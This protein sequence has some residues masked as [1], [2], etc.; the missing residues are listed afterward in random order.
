M[1]GRLFPVD[2]AG[3]HAAENLAQGVEL[4]ALAG[5]EL[6]LLAE[7][8]VAGEEAH[9]LVADGGDVGRDGDLALGGVDNLFPDKAKRPLPAHPDAAD[10]A[11]AAPGGFQIEPHAAVGGKQGEAFGKGGQ[12][13]VGL[14]GDFGA[15]GR[16]TG[17]MGEDLTVDG[18]AN[19]RGP[20]CSKLDLH[21]RPAR[22][23][24][25]V[26]QGKPEDEIHQASAREPENW[27]DKADNQG[28]RGPGRQNQ[29]R[30]PGGVDH[31]LARG[32]HLLDER[33][34]RFVDLAAFDFGGRG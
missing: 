1:L 34:D 2:G 23:Q 9:G 16:A 10:L 4:G 3:V 25:G 21:L 31:D 30:A 28:H 29:D 8:G 5:V 14:D 19:P 33:R 6:D 15:A 24:D 13:G 18:Q 22:T 17:E 27:R 20:G 11:L 32:L 7:H 12:A 26:H